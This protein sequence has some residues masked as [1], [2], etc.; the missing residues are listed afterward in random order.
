MDTVELM[1]RTPFFAGAPRPALEQL[2][3]VSVNRTYP[4]GAFVCRQ[5]DAGTS[6]MLVT[7]GAVKLVTVSLDGDEVLL[8]TAN[9]GDAFGELAALDGGPRTASAITLEPTTVLSVPGEEVR[10]AMA[11]HPTLLESV[12]SA[13]ASLARRATQQRCD[14]VFHDLPGRVAKALLELGGDDG[15]ARPRL[16]QGELAL[17]TGGTR[18]S[19]NQALKA[20]EGAGWI[21][22]DGRSIRI[23]D[24]GELQRRVMSKH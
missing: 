14:L 15:L 22:V 4:K 23:I 1:A 17:L 5:G 9:A 7:S 8:A 13:L 24:R 2:A 3:A 19:V 21:S 12:M 10:R 11:A 16:H 20:F 18:Q 6:M